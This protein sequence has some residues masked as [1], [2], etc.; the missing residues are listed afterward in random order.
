MTDLREST[1]RAGRQTFSLSNRLKRVLWALVYS[2]LFRFSPRPCHRWRSFLLSAFGAKM[3]KGCHVY[4]NVKIW[5]PWN[6]VIE[7]EAE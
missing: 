3:G 4:S 7:D 2:T 1:I 5:A 6:L